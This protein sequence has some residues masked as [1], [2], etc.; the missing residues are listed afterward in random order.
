[1]TKSFRYTPTLI[2][3]VTDA[4][5]EEVKSWQS[6]PLESIYPIVYLDCIYVKARD[7]GMVGAKVVYLALSVNLSGK[8]ELLGIWI[9]QTE[10]A[11]FWLS[12]VTELKNQGV[13]NIFVACVDGLKGFPEAIEAAYSKTIIQL[14]IIHLVRYSLN[15]VSWKLLKLVAADL[16]SIST[17]AT[18][19]EAEK[20]LLAF[21]EK[22][23]KD[24]PAIVK[25]W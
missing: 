2:S 20:Q 12:V 5:I 8:K 15:F 13:Q 18:V 24:Y 19:T 22:W 21:T 10:G 14:C 9:A 6:R 23:G 11:K 7:N 4:V 25:S 17:A 16:R 1:M 3:A